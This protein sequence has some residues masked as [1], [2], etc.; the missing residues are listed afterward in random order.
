MSEAV[1]VHIVEDDPSMRASL[2]RL[3]GDGGY[4][5]ALFASAEEFL[6]AARPDLA[7]CVLLD[8]RLPGMSGLELQERLVQRGCLLPVVFLTAHGELAAGVRA[9]KQ[10]AVDFLEKPVPADT[11]FTAIAAAIARDAAARQAREDL[12][13]LTARV[14]SLSQRERE[15]WLRIVRGQLNKQVAYDLG[16]VERTVKLHRA[17]A[18]TKLGAASLADLVLAAER[19]GLMGRTG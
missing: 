7:G 6:A 14:A 15:V 19:L 11:L 4:Q 3:V 8:L 16:I 9:M 2:A 12:A 17:S 13:D 10:G 1:T 5:L 18:M